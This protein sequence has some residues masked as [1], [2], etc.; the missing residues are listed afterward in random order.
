MILDTRN[1]PLL[2]HDDSGKSTCTLV[3]SLI[4]RM[5]RWSLTG[6]FAEGDMFAGPAGGAEGGGIGE[7]GREVSSQIAEGSEAGVY[8]TSSS[9]CFSRGRWRSIDDINRSGSTSIFHEV[10]RQVLSRHTR[11]GGLPVSSPPNHDTSAKSN[12]H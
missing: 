5:Q 8:E 4:R 10:R 11:R 3:C 7:A 12:A 2:I 1:H 9:Q 6:V